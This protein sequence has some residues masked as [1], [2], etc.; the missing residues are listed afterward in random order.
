MLTVLPIPLWLEVGGGGYG[1][2]AVVPVGAA[3]ATAIPTTTPKAS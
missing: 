3:T 2:T 1:E